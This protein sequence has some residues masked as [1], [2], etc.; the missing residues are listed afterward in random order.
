M[1][2]KDLEEMVLDDATLAEIGVMWYKAN[3]GEF[4]ALDE[5]GWTDEPPEELDSIAMDAA[6]DVLDQLRNPED[7]SAGIIALN[8]LDD[9]ADAL[10][11]VFAEATAA[12]EEDYDAWLETLDEP[13]EEEPEDVAGAADELGGADGVSEVEYDALV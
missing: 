4:E 3:P 12:S 13:E 2:S 6:A 7:G 8:P 5:E 1:A 10:Y 9:V 11:F